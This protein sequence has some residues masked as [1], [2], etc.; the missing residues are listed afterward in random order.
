MAVSKTHFSVCATSLQSN[1][2]SVIDGKGCCWVTVR[3]VPWRK[4]E[5]SRGAAGVQSACCR[6]AYGWIVRTRRIK[7]QA[8]KMR[9]VGRGHGRSRAGERPEQRCRQACGLRGGGW[10]WA[11]GG[12]LRRV[13]TSSHWDNVKL[14][15]GTS[16]S[17]RGAMQNQFCE[18]NSGTCCDCTP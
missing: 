16:W 13:M 3:C 17:W 14:A 1:G 6:D 11:M 2:K 4:R 5:L 9:P 7:L 10:S 8:G 12:F 18:A 15:L